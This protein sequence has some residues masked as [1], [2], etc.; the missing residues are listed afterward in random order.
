MTQYFI[1]IQVK[2]GRIEFAS[3]V[4]RDSDFQKIVNFFRSR[5][6]TASDVVLRKVDRVELRGVENPLIT[7]QYDNVVEI[8]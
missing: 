7:Q 2:R 1:D 8:Q 4:G 6:L 5:N 3:E